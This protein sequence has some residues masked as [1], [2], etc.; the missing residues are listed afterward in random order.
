MAETIPVPVPYLINLAK[1]LAR[2]ESAAESDRIPEQGDIDKL[3][4]ALS[5]LTCNLLDAGIPASDL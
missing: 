2:L 5:L 1:L 3:G 4:T